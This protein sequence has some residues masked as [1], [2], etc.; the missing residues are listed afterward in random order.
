M[1]MTNARIGCR[2]DGPISVST[3]H[4]DETGSD[5]AA[6]D[7]SFFDSATKGARCWSTSHIRLLALTGRQGSIHRG[8]IRERTLGRVFRSTGNFGLGRVVQ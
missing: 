3:E 1:T 2:R 4:N 6:S 7:E 8:A 5:G